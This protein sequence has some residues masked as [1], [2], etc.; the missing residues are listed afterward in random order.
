MWVVAPEDV[1]IWAGT[2]TEREIDE[3]PT[4]YKADPASKVWVSMGAIPDSIA[5]YKATEA[6]I[7][8]L[9][10]QILNLRTELLVIKALVDKEQNN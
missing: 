1:P 3:L 8:A 9:A 5:D 7:Q 6:A 4:M 10:G 2:L